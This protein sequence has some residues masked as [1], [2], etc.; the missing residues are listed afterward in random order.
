MASSGGAAEDKQLLWRFSDDSSMGILDHLNA[1]IYAIDSRDWTWIIAIWT[2]LLVIAVV[3]LKLRNKETVQIAVLCGICKK[4]NDLFLLIFFKVGLTLSLEYLNRIAARN[5]RQFAHQN[6]FDKNGVFIG[7][8]FGTPLIILAV[9][10]LFNGLYQSGKYLIYVK[11][12]QL[13]LKIKEEQRK[14][15]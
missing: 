2:T 12:R 1:F 7:T 11:K 14:S 3:V 6:Y 5:W 8:L 15:E 4:F 9:V 13:A 10:I